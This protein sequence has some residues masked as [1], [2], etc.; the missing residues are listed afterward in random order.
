MK[1]ESTRN[2]METEHN[3]ATI[4]PC[5]TRRR[6]LLAS[7]GATLTTV[8]LTSCSKEEAAT[9]GGAVALDAEVAGYTRKKIA[10]LGTLE[11][12]TPLTFSYPYDDLNSLNFLVKLGV[13]AGGGVGP[14]SD[15]VAYSTLCTHMGGDFSDTGKTYLKEHKIIGPCPLH[16]TTFDL[17]RYGM[18]VAGQATESLPQVVLEVDGDDVYAT[19]ILG[20]I[21][22]KRDSEDVF[23]L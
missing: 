20:L 13:P 5:M 10:Q 17:T 11:V 15:I 18:V 12:D 16:L 7:G 23:V 22:G 2:P 1:R 4:R 8:F 3:S 19:G 21:Y 14:E 9:P 6:F